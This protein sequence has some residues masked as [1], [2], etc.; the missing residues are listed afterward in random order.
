MTFLDWLLKDTPPDEKARIHD[1]IAA[2]R[3]A[4]PPCDCDP[5]CPQHCTCPTTAT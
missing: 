1:N 3:A 4:G 2:T 5:C